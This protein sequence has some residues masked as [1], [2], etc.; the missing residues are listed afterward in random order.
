M[1]DDTTDRTPLRERFRQV[2]DETEALAAPLSAEDQ[3]IQ[4][5]PDASPTKWHRAHTTWFFE[6]FLLKPLLPGYEQFHPDFAYIFNSYY[7]AAGPRHPRPNRGLLSRPGVTDVAAYRAHV[8]A[9]MQR[10]LD[11]DRAD[12]AALVRTGLHHEQQHE[13]GSTSVLV[14]PFIWR[15][16]Y[17]KSRAA[18]HTE[19]FG[20][21]GRESRSRRHQHN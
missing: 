3:T 6:T 16:L 9:A 12:V 2:R 21:S 17:R 8:D 10:L 13:G 19:R 11:T 15:R 18:D 1:L 4:S 14:A 7:V 5:M 20:D